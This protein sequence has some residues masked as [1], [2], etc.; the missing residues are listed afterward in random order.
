MKILNTP[1]LIARAFLLAGVAFFSV[2]AFAENNPSAVI[3]IASIDIAPSALTKFITLSLKDHPDLLAAKADVESAK[4]ALRA[5]D[6][7]I[8]NPQ[9]ELDYEDAEVTTQTVGISQTIDWG[10]QQGSRN[11]VANAQ[12]VKAMAAYEMAT[13]NIMNKVLGGFAEYQTGTELAQLSRQTFELMLGFKQI[14]EQRYRAGDLNQVELNLARLAYNQALMDQAGTLSNATEARESL[15]ALLGALPKTVPALPE[16]LP[17]PTLQDNLESFLQ[18]LP[19]IRAQLADVEIARKQVELRKSEKAWDPTISVS[20][21]T[22]GEEDLIGFNLSI[23]LNIRNSFSAEVDA[24]QQDLIA[25]QQRTQLA[26]RDARGRLIVT[27]ERYKNLLNAW[28]SW[29]ENSRD[30]VDQ[31][32]VLIKQLW[33]AGDISAADYLLQLKQA[34]ETQATGFELRNQLWQ[35]AFDWMSQT[36]TIDNW[37]NI[38]IMT[39]ANKKQD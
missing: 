16:Q 36:S 37:L 8:Y 21:G 20:A 25:N 4:A 39:P 19:V 22:E 31:Q 15:R 7:A 27:T 34:L 1:Q 6:Q 28:N 26:Y 32:L 9:L 35:V 3:G 11:A 33:Q 29:R 12:L 23:P 10:D 17:A 18:Q 13:Q 2:N 24:A 38:E 14:A 5:A 30:S